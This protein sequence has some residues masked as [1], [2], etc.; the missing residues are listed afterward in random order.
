MCKGCGVGT[1][2]GWLACWIVYWLADARCV[3]GCWVASCRAA[4]GGSSGVQ[5]CRVAGGW[6]AGYLA[7]RH[8]DWLAGRLLRGL[9]AKNSV[10]KYGMVW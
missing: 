2:A 1:E 7:G 3:L 9:Q 6:L 8:N 5:D 4:A 10:S